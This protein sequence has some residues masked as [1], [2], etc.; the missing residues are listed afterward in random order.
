[1][2]RWLLPAL[3]IVVVSATLLVAIRQ[4]IILTSPVPIPHSG[5]MRIPNSAYKYHLC[6]EAMAFAHALPD[7]PYKTDYTFRDPF[8]QTSDTIIPHLLDYNSQ[9]Q[10]VSLSV[11]ILITQVATFHEVITQVHELDGISVILPDRQS[12][13]YHTEIPQFIL[14]SLNQGQP[15]VL[16]YTCPEQWVWK[17]NA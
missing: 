1:M 13:L 7:N 4:Y 17:A 11:E 16:D 10:T 15:T 14:S 9:T 2:K 6:T 8:R 5:L 12:H 3:A